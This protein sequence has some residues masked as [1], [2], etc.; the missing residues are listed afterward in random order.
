MGTNLSGRL[1]IVYVAADDSV[2]QFLQ[3]ASG[4]WGGTSL[5]T[6]PA[7][8]GKRV[9]AVRDSGGDGRLIAFYVGLDDV[10][11]RTSQSSTS[12]GSL[13]YSPVPL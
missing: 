12:D 4:S 10:T 3:S 1:H 7:V 5:L 6:S 2:R 13:F 9:A 11:Y 8:K